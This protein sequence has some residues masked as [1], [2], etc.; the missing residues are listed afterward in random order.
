MAI[1]Y[2]KSNKQEQEPTKIH[3]TNPSIALPCCTT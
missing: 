3:L 2:S 1:L